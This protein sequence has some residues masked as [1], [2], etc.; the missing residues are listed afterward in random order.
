MKLCCRIRSYISNYYVL[1]SAWSMI[2]IMQYHLRYHHDSIH[3]EIAGKSKGVDYTVP[4]DKRA[5]HIPSTQKY[6][7]EE[8]LLDLLHTAARSLVM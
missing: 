6:P 2:L 7:V 8:V 3:L 1:L 5:D 4:P